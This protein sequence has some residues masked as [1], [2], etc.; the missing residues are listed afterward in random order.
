MSKF[1]I[2]WDNGSKTVEVENASDLDA[3]LDGIETEKGPGG[4]AFVVDITSGETYKGIPVGLHMSVGHP[5]RAKVIWVGPGDGIG[6]QPDV[7]PWA[8]DII[9]FDYGHLPTEEEPE[10]LRVT[11]A[12]ARE[13][14]RQFIE[15]GQ[16]P[17]CLSWE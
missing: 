11:P 10:Y 4:R 9:A 3:V 8:G 5:D 16:R 7:A 1:E 13:A 15:T 12:M 14:A 6:Y 17:T 2:Q